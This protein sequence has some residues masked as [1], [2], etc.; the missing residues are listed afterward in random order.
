LSTIVGGIWRF[1]DMSWIRFSVTPLEDMS[2]VFETNP[3]NTW[4]MSDA[5]KPAP[6]THR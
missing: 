1:H 6:L 3:L 4:N 5:D 2:T